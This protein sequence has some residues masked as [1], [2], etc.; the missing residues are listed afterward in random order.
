MLKGIFPAIPT[1]FSSTGEIEV[2]AQK[3]VIRFALG[4]GAHG[5]VF[6]G[7]ASEY[8]ALSPAERGELIRLLVREVDGKV[9]L[10]AGI[11]ASQVQEVIALGQEAMNNGIS[12][13]MLMAPHHL[14]LETASHE[15]FFREIT[16]ALPGGKIVLQNAPSP[17]GAG[18]QAQHILRL[19]KGNQAIAYVKE[20]TLPSGPTITALL[21][22]KIDHLIGV[23]GGGGARYIIDEFRRGAI[24]AVPAVEIVDLHVAL[25]QAF[26]QGDEKKARELYQLSLPLLTAQKIYRMRLTKYLL[27]KRGVVD[28]PYIRVPLPELDPFAQQDV[29]QILR[30]LQDSKA[31]SWEG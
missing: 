10:I 15:S 17:I 12:H 4:A 18:L 14:G 13:L 5:I 24:G 11:G 16:N 23:F 22:E 19:V 7:V 1:C 27:H 6:P 30:D 9:P 8:N 25:F 20:E 3:K 29:D 2:D 28:A 21:N 31:L 26:E